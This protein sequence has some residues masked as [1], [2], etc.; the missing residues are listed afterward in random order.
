MFI[1]FDALIELTGLLLQVC[2]RA[3]RVSKKSHPSGG[4]QEVEETS[5]SVDVGET[6]PPPRQCGRASRRRP[7]SISSCSFGPFNWVTA[8]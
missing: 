6:P 2:T 7:A 1:R 5:K 4:K 3:E 8:S